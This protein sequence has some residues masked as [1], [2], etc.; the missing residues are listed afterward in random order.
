MRMPKFN[1]YRDGE[2]I[3]T[4]TEIQLMQYIHRRHSFSFSHAI[5]FEGYSYE[6]V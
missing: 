3:F 4:G 2:L 1:L 5:Q 6:Q